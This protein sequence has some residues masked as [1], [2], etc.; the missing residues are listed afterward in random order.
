MDRITHIDGIP[1]IWDDELTSQLIAPLGLTLA[2]KQG[3]TLRDLMTNGPESLFKNSPFGENWD[4]RLALGD[5]EKDK[6]KNDPPGSAWYYHLETGTD[7]TKLIEMY[8]KDTSIPPGYGSDKDQLTDLSIYYETDNGYN[9]LGSVCFVKMNGA[10]YDLLTNTKDGDYWRNWLVNDIADNQLEKNLIT[11]NSKRLREAIDYE[12]EE[13]G[14]MDMVPKIGSWLLRKLADLI[15]K[16]LL[17]EKSWNANLEDYDPL[18]PTGNIHQAIQS[19]KGFKKK[20]D[21]FFED[22][23]E[24]AEWCKNNI[25]FTGEFLQKFIEVVID[26]FSTVI[27][28]IDSIV[29]VIDSVVE[30]IRLINAFICGVLNELIEMAAS[31]VDLAAL[32]LSLADKAERQM[33]REALENIIESFRKEPDKLI[34]LVKEGYNNLLERYNSDKTAY[35][36]AYHLGEDVVLVLTLLELVFSAVKLLRKLPKPFTRIKEWVKRLKTRVPSLKNAEIAERLKTIRFKYL[37]KP[38]I[39]LKWRVWISHTALDAKRIRELEKLRAAVK[40]IAADNIATLKVKVFLKDGTVKEFEYIAHA[41]RGKKIRL[42]GSKPEVVGA[43]ELTPTKDFWDYGTKRKQKRWFDS[44][45]KMLVQMDKDLA[46]LEIRSTIMEMES[47]FTPCTICRREIL[48]R[49]E[50]YN[51][52]VFVQSSKFRNKNRKLRQVVNNRDFKELLKQIN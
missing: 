42:E 45:N 1:L 6:Y 14:G 20:T 15:R 10:L 51:A 35:E 18:L 49:R 46:G 41:G 32:M 33:V 28:A 34:D 16:G 23:G 11:L 47:A 44:E 26:I 50:M 8:L 5:W 9:S 24:A 3:R 40:A 27:D 17:P 25:P 48:V 12:L 4:K 22:A 21:A 36:K 52:K 7:G 29:Q 19:W 43:P 39:N 30:K 13:G 37:E 38:V 2:D 31:L